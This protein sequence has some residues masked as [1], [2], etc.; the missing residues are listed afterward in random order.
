[1]NDE[2]EEQY[3]IKG[4]IQDLDGGR[5]VFVGQIPGDNIVY[6]KLQNGETE[7]RFRLSFEAAEVLRDLLTRISER[8][9][10]SMSEW[11][12]LAHVI[13]KEPIDDAV[14]S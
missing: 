12:V 6:I 8:G 9:L 2:P 5:S 14:S 11:T 10:M 13:A 7:T 1:M 4:L 3:R